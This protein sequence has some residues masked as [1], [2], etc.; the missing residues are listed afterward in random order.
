M[1]VTLSIDTVSPTGS[2]SIL[3][4][5]AELDFWVLGEKEKVSERLLSRL[6][7]LLKKNDLSI[8]DIKK[9]V[10]T[11]GPGSFTGI[12][13]GMATVKGLS[14]ALEKHGIHVEKQG[15]SLLSTLAAVATSGNKFIRS[16]I[17]FAD[18]FIFQDFKR[19]EDTLSDA[20]EI[21]SGNEEEVFEKVSN[22]FAI[23]YNSKSKI[24]SRKNIIF[25]PANLALFAFLASCSN[26]RKFDKPLYFSD[27]ISKKQIK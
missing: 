18:T 12:R 26:V 11:V 24:F 21:I 16:V 15:V 13:V 27:V 2:I 1:Q 20:G 23:V 3:S 17:S 14:F 25:P 9:I 22:D 8:K 5:S 4:G 10:Y 7:Y 19:E 6:V